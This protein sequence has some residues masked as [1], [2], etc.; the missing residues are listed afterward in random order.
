MRKIL[1]VPLIILL[2]AVLFIGTRFANQPLYSEQEI[3]EYNESLVRTNSEHPQTDPEDEKDPPAPE[4]A[5]PEIRAVY[6]SGLKDRGTVTAN[7]VYLEF[8]SDREIVSVTANGR[9]VPNLTDATITTEG[10][11]EVVVTDNLDQESTFTFTL[12][13]E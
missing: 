10:T 1:I 3:Q 5:P 6:P 4:T 13:K 9:T 8:S 2:M 7:R 12:I 11:Y